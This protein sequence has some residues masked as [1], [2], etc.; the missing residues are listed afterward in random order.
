[1]AISLG[2]SL[3]NL[4]VCEQILIQLKELRTHD[5]ENFLFLVVAIMKLI[6]KC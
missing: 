5:D 1:M 3:L 4:H 2:E 6:F